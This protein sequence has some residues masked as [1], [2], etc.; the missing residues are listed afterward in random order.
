MELHLTEKLVFHVPVFCFKDGELLTVNTEG[1]D[2]QLSSFLVDAG[3]DSWYT[4]TCTGHYAGRSYGQR[5]WTVFCTSE[6]AEKAIAAFRTAFE[7][8]NSELMQEAYAYEHNG[9]MTVISL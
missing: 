5:L 1:F 3:I 6:Q 8:H 4:T 9:Q 2:K 7:Q